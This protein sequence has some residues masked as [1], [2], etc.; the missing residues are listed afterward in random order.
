MLPRNAFKP[1]SP[2]NAN[3]G[4]RPI[5]LFCNL[6]HCVTLI[7]LLLGTNILGEN[8][9]Q[10]VDLPLKPTQ[11]HMEAS[12]AFDGTASY[13]YDFQLPSNRGRYQPK[14]VLTYNSRDKR[15]RGFGVGWTPSL[16]YLEH[17]PSL[18]PTYPKR[19]PW[20]HLDNYSLVTPTGSYHLDSWYEI[21]RGHGPDA[22]EYHY[23]ARNYPGSFHISADWAG[24]DDKGNHYDFNS[25][26]DYL[27][28]VIDVDGN[29]TRYTYTG[30]PSRPGHI[31]GATL[32]NSIEYNSYVVQSPGT[33]DPQTRYLTKVN[34]VYRDNPSPHTEVIN[35]EIQRYSQ[36]LD[37]IEITRQLSNGQ[38]VLLR[39]YEFKYT[40]SSDSLQYLLTA[41]ELFGQGNERSKRPTLFSYKVED[42]RL[43]D[44][45]LLNLALA[46]IELPTGPPDLMPDQNLECLDWVG[47]INCTVASVTSLLDVDGDGM[48]DLV[49]GDQRKGLR[50]ARNSTAPGF[51]KVSFN[52]VG[53]LAMPN[54]IPPGIMPSVNHRNPNALRWY[55]PSSN[56]SYGYLWTRIQ[57][58]NGDGFPD[59]IFYREQG[60]N[61]E[62]GLWVAW[63]NGQGFGTAMKLDTTSPYRKWQ[64]LYPEALAANQSFGISLHSRAAKG[65]TVDLRDMTGDGVADFVIALPN[66][67][68][69]LVYPLDLK[70]MR[71]TPLSGKEFP[72]SDGAVLSSDD[73]SRAIIDLNGDGL[74][75]YIVAAA[76]KW[77]VNYNT[78]TSLV[79]ADSDDQWILNTP[80]YTPDH[81]DEHIGQPDRWE[82][83]RGMLADFNGDGLPDYVYREDG[84]GC[85]G[86][87]TC[88][89]E[90]SWNRGWGLGLTSRT[91]L[92]LINIHDDDIYPYMLPH[93][94]AHGIE[95]GSRGMMIDLNGDG[96]MDFFRSDSNGLAKFYWGQALPHDG[97]DLL[98]SVET[99]LGEKLTFTYVPSVQE[100][101]GPAYSLLRIIRH[102][103]PGGESLQEFFIYGE[104]VHIPSPR[105]E[106]VKQFAGFKETW[107]FKS[108]PGD[109]PYRVVHTKWNTESPF[110]GLPRITREGFTDI[111][112]K[113]PSYQ[114][115]RSV[116]TT[117]DSACSEYSGTAIPF[118][119]ERVDD[120]YEEGLDLPL[121]STEKIDCHDVDVH[122]NV[123]V[124]TIDPDISQLD[125][126]I[127]IKRTFLAS[128]ETNSC[129]SCPL[130]EEIYSLS[131]Q[132]TTT[133]K[134]A[135]R[136]FVYDAPIDEYDPTPN[137]I[138]IGKGHLNYI[139]HWKKS[140]E[141]GITDTFLIPQK[142]SYHNNG[143]ISKVLQTDPI[144]EHI[145]SYDE[146][147][148][149]PIREITTDRSATARPLEVESG[150]DSKTGQLVFTR[151]PF[152]T[153]RVDDGT[154]HSYG[155]DSFGRLIKIG[156]SSNPDQLNTLKAYY[157]YDDTSVPTALKT[158]TFSSRP[159][160]LTPASLGRSDV[161]LRIQYLDGQGNVIQIRERLGGTTIAEGNAAQI[162]QQ[163][164][165]FLVSGATWANGHGEIWAQFDPFYSP[166]PSFEL[167]HDFIK[168]LPSTAHLNLSIFDA[169]GRLTC[170]LYRSVDVQDD[171]SPTRVLKRPTQCK[172]IEIEPSQFQSATQISISGARVN[173]NLFTMHK[174]SQLSPDATSGMAESKTVFYDRS[175]RRRA[176]EDA[177]GNRL[178]RHYNALGQMIGIERHAIGRADA[179]SMVRH[180]YDTAGRLVF[181][182]DQNAGTKRLSY[183][184]SGLLI[185]EQLLAG[186]N[187]TLFQSKRFIYGDLGRLSQ[188][189]TWDHLTG[190]SQPRVLAA[191]HYDRPFDNDPAYAFTS[192]RLSW[193]EVP[194]VTRIR[195]GYNRDGVNTIRHQEFLKTSFTSSTHA[196]IGHD[197][198]V[199]QTST[200]VVIAGQVHTLNYKTYYDSFKRPIELSSTDR[201]FF[202]VTNLLGDSFDS[203][204]RLRSASM[205]NGLVTYQYQFHEMTN[206]QLA[207]LNGAI[208][209][210]PF[211]AFSNTKYSRN[212]LTYAEDR[213]VNLSYTYNYDCNG[214]LI[215][216]VSKALS[217]QPAREYIEKYSFSLSKE[218][219]GCRDSDPSLWN[220]EAS[221]HLSAEGEDDQ[222][223]HYQYQPSESTK[224]DAVTSITTSR[225]G[226][227]STQTF[228]YNEMGSLTIKKEANE[229]YSYDVNNKL[230]KMQTQTS[231]EFLD[232]GP[233]GLLAHRGIQMNGQ[234]GDNISIFYAGPYATITTRPN[235]TPDVQLH[236]ILAGR[237]I[238]SQT[239]NK[240]V[241][242]HRDSLGSV[243]ATS[244]DGGKKG[245]TYRYT[246]YGQRFIS[247][248]NGDASSDLGFI[249]GLTLSNQIVHLEN[250][251][252]DT[253]LKK[254][255]Q[256]DKLDPL[257]YTYA[258]G[259][260]ANLIDPSG[261][262]PVRGRGKEWDPWYGGL[263]VGLYW[264]LEHRKWVARNAAFFDAARRSSI[265]RVPTYDEIL[266]QLWAEYEEH[267]E[268]WVEILTAEQEM[269]MN[270]MPYLTPEPIPTSCPLAENQKVL[271]ALNIDQEE[272]DAMTET[273][274]VLVAEENMCKAPPKKTPNGLEQQMGAA[275]NSAVWLLKKSPMGTFK[276]LAFL[277]VTYPVGQLAATVTEFALL[278]ALPFRLASPETFG[279]LGTGTMWGVMHAALAPLVSHAGTEF[280]YSW[281]GGH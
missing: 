227:P 136:I 19:T 92:G 139:K 14:F 102:E 163:L 59:F 107:V 130:E 120:I 281:V 241:Y 211:I 106:R 170:R 144:V 67:Q 201:V 58:L 260:P 80:G 131:P 64:E 103:N 255:L 268:N 232:Y 175:G 202:A 151:G 264:K 125:D 3:T 81:G 277:T 44:K 155:Y 99:P 198:R 223:Y 229:R 38:S 124:Q 188:I 20:A 45:L 248:D 226:A 235:Q 167:P 213:A 258:A 96:L 217:N 132:G 149:V 127:Q 249:G 176:I 243:I 8:I 220:L 236:V 36:Q 40:L 26:G 275:A 181:I 86:L 197:N 178:L 11:L 34:L 6:I 212:R 186:T 29:S 47:R 157:E 9:A 276:E 269:L 278:P 182:E 121:R 189:E 128:E 222:I 156:S 185:E 146:Y 39:A 218:H 152:A 231:H 91:K 68:A 98:R 109:E 7:G 234:P 12:P 164:S 115:T 116:S 159:S 195:L 100:F 110:I 50:W 242:Y 97:S 280:A 126:Q 66:G 104:P 173:E 168:T 2:M 93:R 250:R 245:A 147:G 87:G 239:I 69:W 240:A 216:S 180:T 251:D 95:Q 82:G 238:A 244:L 259:D 206:N 203:L 118:V 89:I 13:S 215:R 140:Q 10:A 56:S 274:L 4:Y 105:F 129:K 160:D 21:D 183:S 85:P 279:V 27:K 138:R 43:P 272:M 254:F 78:G 265:F 174:V 166:V 5:S 77:S 137:S 88:P 119:A 123:L 252:L 271:L 225:Q 261:L 257:R 165:G 60:T 84:G 112:R 41:I 55:E 75:D 171:A 79:P 62:K 73:G 135:H 196:Q 134:L 65:I 48:P 148:V 117:W 90:I 270:S 210:A 192:D 200:Q 237:R 46:E 28:E 101:P 150:Y 31:R 177:T 53:L 145:Y 193:A 172:S 15:N 114:M 35:G 74:S 207:S 133:D 23:R 49:W 262:R 22:I 247:D 111:I 158:Y 154:I 83:S 61:T 267:K 25:A 1:T 63:G 230:V 54:N 37:R 108:T 204:G 76:D 122:G 209:H 263:P 32:L 16:T 30:K 219:G 143:L 113:P 94:D 71:F 70:E 187:R 233:D 256:P 205:D 224:P 18:T 52:A 141:P 142:T 169:Q 179:L 153:D 72:I 162:K 184:D 228:D 214:R 190:P 208:G 246:P 191:Y 57:D 199:L 253:R 24:E 273:P 161:Q 266:A 17:N 33:S 221:Q 51:S 194:G 42:P